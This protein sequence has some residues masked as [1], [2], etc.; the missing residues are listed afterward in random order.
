MNKVAPAIA[1]GCTVVIKPSPLASITTVMLGELSAKA[2]VPAGVLNIVT[3]GPPAGS[4]ASSVALADHP[5]LDKLSFTGSSAT[6]EKLLH[7][8]AARLRPTSLELGGKGAIVVFEDADVSAAVDWIMVGI[9]LCTGQVC[10]A[11]SRLIIHEAIA[12][13][14]LAELKVRTEKIALGNPLSEGT[15]MGPLVSKSQQES[16][17]RCINGGIADG[18]NVLTGG[19]APPVLPDDFAAGAAGCYVQPTIFT[20][21][22][23]TSAV[24][25]EEIF[26]P[27]LATKTFTTEEEA[28][29]MANASPYG[30]AHAV[31]SGDPA[32]CSR[33][34]GLLDAGVVYENCSQVGFVTTPFGGCKQSGFGREWGEV[35]LDEYVH[36]KT[37]TSA[38]SSSVSWKWYGE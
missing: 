28:V 36:H 37:V 27:I 26:G 14:V 24:W 33:V 30:L 3:G 18:C 19:V 4:P 1:A 21:V 31:L 2:G 20:D 25:T 38:T 35:G 10:S 15:V 23:A 29:A 7:A 13:E 34:A 11:T 12:D 16:V 6:G 17:L 8:S 22:P 5:L 9:F 32:R